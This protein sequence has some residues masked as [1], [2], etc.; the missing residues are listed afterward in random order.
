MSNR[1]SIDAYTEHE[2][3]KKGNVCLLNSQNILL[4]NKQ[5]EKLLCYDDN[6]HHGRG[7]EKNDGCKM[8]YG[9]GQY[10]HTCL[11]KQHTL[12]KKTNSRIQGVGPFSM[13]L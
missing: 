2:T 8:D 10:A 3:K 4:T 5:D 6:E 13:I 7:P 11:N 9:Y 1:L 12:K